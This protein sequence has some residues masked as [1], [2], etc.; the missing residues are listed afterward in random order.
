MEYRVTTSKEM[1]AL[2]RCARCGKVVLHRVILKRRADVKNL[3]RLDSRQGELSQQLHRDAAALAANRSPLTFLG[4][5]IEGKC[6]NCQERQPWMCM[7]Y[8]LWRMLIAIFAITAIATLLGDRARQMGPVV[9]AAL[10]LSVAALVIHAAV[11]LIATKRIS[12]NNPIFL[13][14]TVNEIVLKA[15]NKQEYIDELRESKN[16]ALPVDIDAILA[17]RTSV[18]K[19][20]PVT[21]YCKKCG[22]P[23]HRSLQR[24]A[25]CGESKETMM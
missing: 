15:A 19:E 22:S 18:R 5:T 9:I 2:Y 17:S 21:W 16:S 10:A 3:N 20:N 6:P 12:Q 14:D 8:F 7:S 23:N 13:A 4:K 1:M 25:G 24:C 11:M